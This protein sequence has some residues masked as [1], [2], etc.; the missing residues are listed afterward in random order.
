MIAVIADGALNEA[1]LSF[2]PDVVSLSS[3]RRYRGVPATAVRQQ[4]QLVMY[5]VPCRAPAVA[6][7]AN[8][9]M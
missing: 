5:D 3:L 1:P 6:G 4:L 2:E 7:R 9:P 8:Y